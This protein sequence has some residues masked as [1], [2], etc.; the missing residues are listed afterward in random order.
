M[1]LFIASLIFPAQELQALLIWSLSRF[2]VE[3]NC[4]L[5]WLF[6]VSSKFSQSSDFIFSYRYIF[7]F[8]FL[9]L[10]FFCGEKF[11]CQVVCRIRWSL[12]EMFEASISHGV[13]N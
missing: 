4:W 11:V 2:W 12:S 10:G 8:F 9:F 3:V 6:M 13:S 7:R 5:N 1:C